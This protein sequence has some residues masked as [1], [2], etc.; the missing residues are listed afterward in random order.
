MF[1]IMEKTR[2]G[3][4]WD[5]NAW[6]IFLA[7]RKKYAASIIENIFCYLTFQDVTY[8][9]VKSK[10]SKRATIKQKKMHFQ[11]VTLVQKLRRAEYN[12]CGTITQGY[13]ITCN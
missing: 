12:K 4:V 8:P 5:H 1:A 2:I 11:F 7:S 9:I 6:N 3:C 10:M 13:A